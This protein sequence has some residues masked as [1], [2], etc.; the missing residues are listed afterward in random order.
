MHRRLSSSENVVCD[1]FV[2]PAVVQQLQTCVQTL[3][4]LLST[5]QV[6]PMENKRPAAETSCNST[7]I[8]QPINDTPHITSIRT[9]NQV[10]TNDIPC[11]PTH[12]VTPF[13][14]VPITETSYNSTP[15]TDNPC[16]PTQQRT[17]FAYDEDKFEVCNADIILLVCYVTVYVVS[18]VYASSIGS[19]VDVL[20]IY[21]NS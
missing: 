5:Q 15:T 3:S 21:S 17:E 12:A 1:V 11:T 13:T 8:Q 2:L 7:K 6:Q 14:P 20:R 9:V 18:N 4:S 19:Y 16:T 10:P